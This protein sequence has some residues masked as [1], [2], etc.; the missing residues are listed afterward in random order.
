[1]RSQKILQVGDTDIPTNVVTVESGMED[2]ENQIAQPSEPD[3][4]PISNRSP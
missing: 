2:P 4:E 1:M 3:G